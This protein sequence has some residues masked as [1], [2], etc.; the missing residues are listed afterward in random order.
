MTMSEAAKA[1]FGWPAD[2]KHAPQSPE[3][4]TG[5]Q[6]QAA[7]R[8]GYAGKPGSTPS[9]AY[10]STK[11]HA[12]MANARDRGEPLPSIPGAAAAA[13]GHDPVVKTPRVAR[14][15]RDTGSLSP[16]GCGCG[17]LSKGLFRP[18]HDARLLSRLV[19]SAKDGTS[20]N[21]V[22]AEFDKVGASDKLR[23]KLLTRLDAAGV[24]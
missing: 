11:V 12:Q 16:C 21:D 23:A 10:N 9:H 5:N 1:A 7:C 18:G 19:K 15:P 3:V 4:T 8:C 24:A 22:L 2:L 17:E 6:F 14:A 20:R 13:N